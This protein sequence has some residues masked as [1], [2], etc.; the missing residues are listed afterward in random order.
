[1]ALINY[2]SWDTE[3]VDTYA[4]K[5]PETNLTTAT[6]LLVHESQEAVLF[7]KGKI[8]GKFGPGKHTLTTEN[9]PILHKMYGLPFGKKNPFTAEV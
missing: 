1:M 9:L 2:V 8:V 3:D 6:Q 4:Y 5:F 7:S